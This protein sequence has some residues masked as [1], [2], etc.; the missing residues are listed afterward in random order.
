MSVKEI[1]RYKEFNDFT[2]KSQ[3]GKKHSVSY[4]ETATNSAAGVVKTLKVATLVSIVG[5]GAATAAVQMESP[6]IDFSGMKTYMEEQPKWQSEGP[7]FSV[8]FGDHVHDWD[9]GQILVDATCMEDGTIEFHCRG[10]EETKTE[11]VAAKGHS[12]VYGETVD[13]TCTEDGLSA[14]ESCSVCGTVFK[15][16]EIITATG[17]V[18]KEVEACEATCTENGYTAGSVCEVCGEGLEGTK[19]VKAKGHKFG[20]SKTIKKATCTEDGESQRT[21]SRCG[22]VES[23]V[24]EAGARC[25]NHISQSSHM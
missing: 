8:L 6:I 1:H 11:T 17:H 13:A 19:V 20:K 2:G 24:I 15:E 3:K 25:G 9:E 22:E 4:K 16:A 21:C 14:S 18:P 7:S 5:L 12:I 23:T 10:C